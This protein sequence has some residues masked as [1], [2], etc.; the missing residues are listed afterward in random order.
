MRVSDE[1]Q[2]TYYAYVQ[3]S[4]SVRRVASM[5]GKRV[6]R[7]GRWTYHGF[8]DVVLVLETDRTEQRLWARVRYSGLG[9]RT[10]W[11]PAGSLATPRLVRTRLVIDRGRTRVR[12]FRSGRLVFG[13]RAGVGASSSPTPPGMFF[14]RERLRPRRSDTIYGPLAFGLSAYSPYRTDWPGGGQVG[15]H[16]TNQPG[17][18][19][20]RISNGCIRLRN[21]EILRLGRLMPVGTPVLI[22]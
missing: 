14:I 15:L 1:R 2:R 19:P 3:R 10:G 8:R 16:G 21:A 20:G 6:G 22:R 13:A 7:L 5:R 9:R 17:L 12:L 18:I 4:A 11:V